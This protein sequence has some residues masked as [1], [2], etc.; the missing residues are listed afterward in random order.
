MKLLVA[1]LLLLATP[2]TAETVVIKTGEHGPFTRIV[3]PFSAPAEWR[4]GRTSTGYELE[5]GR[6]EL[7]YDLSHAFD[8]IGRD[9]LR[10]LWPDPDSGRLQIG[11]NCDCHIKA[12]ELRGAILVLDIHDGA[13]PAG[14]AYET[15]LDGGVSSPAPLIMPPRPRSRP[16]TAATEGYDWIAA[17]QSANTG[18]DV[19]G[20]LATV[21][22]SPGFLDFRAALIEQLGRAA[23]EGQVSLQPHIVDQLALRADHPDGEQAPIMAHQGE[24][25][26]L[27]V[28]GT[29]C[30]TPERV[31]LSSWGAEGEVYP[32][33]IVARGS[34]LHEF[35]AVDEKALI[36]TV[37]LHLYYGMGAEARALLAA[38]DSEQRVDPVLK[39]LSYLVEGESPPAGLLAGQET[40]DGPVALWALLAASGKPSSAVAAK[41]VAQSFLNLPAAMRAETA[42]SLVAKLKASGHGAE[43][44]VIAATLSRS[45]PEAAPVIPLVEADQ[46]LHH[47]K[48]QEAEVALRDENLPDL[49]SQGMI[50]RAETAFRL[51]KALPPED[52]ASLEAALFAEGG[53]GPLLRAVALARGL[54]GAFDS[55]FE[56][57]AADA[58]TQ[59]DLWVLLAA[60]GGDDA[61]L[62]HSA[63]LGPDEVAQ[64]PQPTRARVASRL[65]DLGL[66]DLSLPWVEDI[67]EENMLNARIAM[68]RRDGRGAISNLAGEVE[69]EANALRIE[70]FTAIGAYDRAA[71]LLD[72]DGQPEAAARLQRWAGVWEAALP[73]DPADNWSRVAIQGSAVETTQAQ[74]TLAE[75]REGLVRSAETLSAVKALLSDTE[76]R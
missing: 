34:I 76:L 16:V 59:R 67:H 10:S 14:S 25:P 20:S 60:I 55:A 6:P 43:A 23:T 18:A 39:E 33:L 5:P 50:L 64:I 40:C 35:D 3:L 57:A 28:G 24:A 73:A 72:Q 1:A 65:S 58:A 4:L 11:L 51:Q 44:A 21:A 42:R 46:A 70:A 48:P 13:A 74:A 15:A 61:L 26:S 38:F 22:R 17:A 68:N 63:T 12:A 66:P 30:L 8:L 41:S 69:A 19:E 54:D 53:E 52:L 37:R 62:T 29:N 47:D 49:D 9:R 2:V 75:A 7:R 27:S 71:E 45:G 31:D 32:A 56:L 36:N